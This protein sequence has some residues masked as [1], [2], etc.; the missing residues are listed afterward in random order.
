MAIKNDFQF[1]LN[2]APSNKLMQWIKVNT[3]RD[4]I[5]VSKQEILDPITLSGRK[6]YLGHSYYLSVMGYNYSERLKLVNLFFEAK[7]LDTINRM[8]KENIK[9]IVIPTKPVADFNY[10]M[11]N[12]YLDKHLQR[13][14]TDSQIRVYKL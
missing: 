7:D 8:R 9:Y 13:P 2:D 11:D 14:Y 3:R 12:V 5:F 6:N 4:D 10:R 1:Y